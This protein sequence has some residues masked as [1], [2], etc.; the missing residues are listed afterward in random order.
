MDSCLDRYH[1]PKLI[2][3]QTYNLN[4]PKTPKEI[5]ALIK[6]LPTSSTTK[7]PGSSGFSSDFQDRDNTNNPQSKAQNIIR[8]ITAKYAVLPLYCHSDSDT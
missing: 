2:Q 7:I 4:R 3:Y 5:E 1:F 6:C 8:R